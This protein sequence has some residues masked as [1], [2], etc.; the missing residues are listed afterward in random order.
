MLKT[1]I[2]F[3]H[4]KYCLQVQN[5]N[6]KWK[7]VFSDVNRKIVE[8]ERVKLQVQDEDKVR[9]DLVKYRFVERYKEF[10]Q[11]KLDLAD[12]PSNRLQKSSVQCYMTTY[13]KGIKGVIPET[14]EVKKFNVGY[15]KDFFLKMR[16][17]GRSFKS[18]KNS[19]KHIKGFL[20][21]AKGN[22]WI[23]INPLDDFSVLDHPD[24]LPP[25]DEEV[26]RKETV[27]IKNNEIKHLFKSN[28][29][30]NPAYD[31]YLRFTVLTVFAFTGMR[32]S[33]V[34]GL[35][36]SKVNFYN[37]KISIRQTVVRSEIRNFGKRG[38]SI[39]DV[40]MPVYLRSVLLRWKSVWDQ[41]HDAKTQWLFPSLKTQTPLTYGAIRNK[42]LEAY[43]IAGFAKI[44]QGSSGNTKYFRVIENKFKDA[45]SKTFRHFASTALLNA[46]HKYHNLHDNF[47][48]RQ[49]G[50]ESI[51][52]TR[53]LYGDHIIDDIYSEEEAKQQQALD[54]VFN[55]GPDLSELDKIKT[56]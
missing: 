17:N 12:Q 29:P 51:D 46:Q 52:L 16:K 9:A 35:T 56:N 5:D 34:A 28:I 20:K 11:Y 53:G 25:S 19:I 24:L 32:A 41:Y 13:E 23:D 1:K 22:Q 43:H 10:A 48:K 8:K 15:A 21:Y 26:R 45:T 37:N 30:K 36:W 38:A 3:K 49:I 7:Q 42:L 27:T 39:R 14:L 33:E 47:V 50:H 6:L 18:A 31:E 2:A 55:F 40:S 4:G 54:E 44:E